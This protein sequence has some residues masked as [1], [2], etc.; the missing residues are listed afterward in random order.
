MCFIFYL[1]KLSFADLKI[2]Y[3]FPYSMYPSPPSIPV[4][5][6]RQPA[7]R[8]RGGPAERNISVN[9]FSPGRCPFRTPQV[10][11]SLHAPD[12]RQLRLEAQHEY[13]PSQW[14][15]GS[16]TVVDHQLSLNAK[17]AP[18]KQKIWP[19]MLFI[20]NDT[21]FFLF[22]LFLHTGRCRYQLLRP[23]PTLQ[24]P[25]MVTVSRQGGVWI[26]MRI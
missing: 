7:A 21:P 9:V 16:S 10:P 26:K 4:S 22:H 6:G 17:I 2:M 5:H 23:M 25:Y 3:I 8:S 18:C 12:S 15:S 13:F 11:V 24:P 20:Q 19:C 14:G 1:V